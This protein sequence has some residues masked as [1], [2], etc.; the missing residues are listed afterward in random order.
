MKL[1]L[2]SI[3][4]HF[5]EEELMEGSKRKLNAVCDK[6]G[7]LILIKRKVTF[8]LKNHIYFITFFKKIINFLIRSSPV[9]SLQ[10]SRQR[11]S[12]QSLFL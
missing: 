10:I 2:L 4:E 5:G 3:G 11:M 1:A 7:I 6:Q 8:S 9:K 12:F